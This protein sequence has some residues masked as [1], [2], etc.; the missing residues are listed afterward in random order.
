M[1]KYLYRS[2]MAY[3]YSWLARPAVIVLLILA[4]TSF[5]FTLRGRLKGKSESPASLGGAMGSA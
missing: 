2:M 4:A 1:E 3:G 5:F